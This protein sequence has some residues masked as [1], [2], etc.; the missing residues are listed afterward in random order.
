MPESQ[1]DLFL[2]KVESHDFTGGVIGLG[3]VGL[4][5]AMLFTEAGF[6]ALGFDIDARKPEM[7][8]RMTLGFRVASASY[9]IPSLSSVPGVKFSMTTS[10]CSTSRRNSSFPSADCRSIATLLF[11]RLIEKK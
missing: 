2:R 1:L 10:A 11:P 4:P 9:P 3:Y 5:L 8:A 7:L 6:R